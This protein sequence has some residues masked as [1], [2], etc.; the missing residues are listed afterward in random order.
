MESG[1]HAA[2]RG[3]ISTVDVHC[4]GRLPTLFVASN[5]IANHTSDRHLNSLLPT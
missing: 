3:S 1:V 5:N 4:P 2:S